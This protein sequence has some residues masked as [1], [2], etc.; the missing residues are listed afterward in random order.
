MVEPKEAEAVRIIFDRYLNHGYGSQRITSYLAEQGITNRSGNR[1]TNT[2]IQHMLKN[3]SYTGV[4]RSGETVSDIF[5]H[6]QI[7]EPATFEKVQEIIKQRS[8]EYEARRVPLNTRGNALL[9]GNVFCGHC[10]S[11]LTLTTNGKRYVRKDGTVHSTPKIRYTC[12]NKTRHPGQCDGQ[13]G[14]TSSKLDG[15]IEKI[16]KSLFEQVQE[17]PKE[18]IIKSQFSRRLSQ[19]EDCL[20]R[21]KDNLKAKQT[22][23]DEYEGEVLKVIRGESKLDADLLNKLHA[24]AKAETEEAGREVERYQQEVD[25]N[26]ELLNEVSEQY[27]DLLRWADMFEDAPLETK[28][29][30]VSNIISAVRVSRDYEVEMDFNINPQ[31]FGMTMG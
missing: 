25:N 17:Q 29:M 1:F 3:V 30:I 21:A 8:S 16:I 24:G 11:R 12:Y 6:L 7:I 9:S 27:D 18:D 28:K 14:Y 20:S 5:L 2:T 10:G 13:T 23:M 22:V 31:D 19:L 4:L 15:A 26:R